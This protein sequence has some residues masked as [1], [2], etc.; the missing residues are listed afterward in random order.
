MATGR[1][2]KRAVEAIPL[3]SGGARA[4]LWDDVLKGFGLMVT[5]KGSRTYLIQYRIGGRGSPT[6]RYTIGKHGS[7]W[8][9]DKA[10]ERA[11]DLLE[12]VRR[13]I[14]PMD[15][16]RAKLSDAADA[17]EAA[18]RLAFGSY[19]DTFIK[20]HAEGKR[21]RSAG[22]I[23]S[24]FR[25][26]LRPHFADK[27]I[28]SIRR[29]DVQACMDKIAERSGSAANKA[30]S[31]LNKMFEFAVSRGD[32][33]ASPMLG[34]EPPA[35]KTKRERVLKG[36]ELA[37]VWRGAEDLGEPW[38]SWLRLLML[39]GQRRNEVAGMDWKELDLAAAAWIIPGARTKNKRDHLVPLS[40]QALA[41]IQALQPEPKLRKGLL[42]STNGKTPISGYSKTKARLDKL[43]T[44]AIAKAN[45]GSG[46]LPLPLEHWTFHDLRRSFGTGC[47]ALG[48]PKEHVHA[49]LNHSSGDKRDGLAAIYML[50][51]YKDEKT[52]AL[53]AWARHIDALLSGDGGSNVVP[54][55]RRA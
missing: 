52:A 44:A 53:N 42:F 36:A 7:P 12:Q 46:D 27:P 31:W 16:D 47:Q 30:Y 2:T 45:E 49:V 25:R 43:V 40:P 33:S 48:F 17:K 28:T 55:A 35:P 39:L 11:A 51:E 37:H 54:L 5:G 29:T 19:A 8:T 10:R 15:A 26:D 32:L 14:D 4:Y 6:R 20:K 23:R 13:K 34:M 50:H 18:A 22:D 41:I 21:L 1:I 9:A 3:P 24:V 38:R